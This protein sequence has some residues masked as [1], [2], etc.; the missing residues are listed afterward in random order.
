MH[1][2]GMRQAYIDGVRDA[3]EVLCR[4]LRGGLTEGNLHLFGHSVSLPEDPREKERAIRGIEKRMKTAL[5]QA[6][7]QISDVDKHITGTWVE[8]EGWYP[9]LLKVEGTE[10]RV[11]LAKINARS[12]RRSKS[13]RFGG[14]WNW[15]VVES[16]LVGCWMVENGSWFSVRVRKTWRWSLGLWCCR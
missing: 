12:K 15:M 9:A 10:I 7:I 14:N 4:Q 5:Q 13:Q 1:L 2:Q 6:D 11:A 8:I 16:L 3:A